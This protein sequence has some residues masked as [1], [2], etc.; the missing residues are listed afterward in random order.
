MLFT[1]KSNKLVSF[2]NCLVNGICSSLI[3]K[4]DAFVHVHFIQYF[5]N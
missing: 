4:Y 2:K 5:K 3:D 1:S